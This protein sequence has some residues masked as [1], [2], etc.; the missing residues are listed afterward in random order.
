M[1]PRRYYTTNKGVAAVL[2]MKGHNIERCYQENNPKTGRPQ[3]KI[4]FD[5]DIDSGRGH[6]DM[7]F[8]GDITADLKTFYDKLGEVGRQ[9]Y[10]ARR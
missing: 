3:V 6:A 7:F 9:I 1:G 4:E 5:C 10:D 2:L 8:N